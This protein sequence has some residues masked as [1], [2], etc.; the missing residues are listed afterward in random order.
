MPMSEE[1]QTRRYKEFAEGLLSGSQIQASLEMI[2]GLETL[3]D[4]DD[5]MKILTF[6]DKGPV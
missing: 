4:V 3:E 1:E 6:C 5:L 2:K